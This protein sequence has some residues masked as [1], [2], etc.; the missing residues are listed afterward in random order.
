MGELILQNGASLT[1]SGNLTNSGGLYVNTGGSGGSNLTVEGTLTNSALVQIG[2]NDLATTVTAEG[3][4]NSGTFY[5]YVDSTLTTSGNVTNSDEL[6]VYGGL[7]IGGTLTNSD[8]VAIGNGSQAT[9]VTAQGLSNTA[10]G[11]IDIEGG[12]TNR[13]LLNITG[14]A[15]APTIWTG[16]LDISGDGVLEFNN[17]TIGTIASGAEIYLSGSE[18]WVADAGA[19]T[20]NT[21]LSGLSSIVG[22]LILQNGASLTTSGNLTNS[23][24]L[25]VNTGGSGGSNLT[26][27]GTLTNS[28]LV[29]IGNNDLATT[30]TAEG[31]NNSGTFYIYVDSTLTT[32]GNVTNSDE[33]FVY[34][35]LTIGGTLTNSDV[36]AIGNGSQATTVTAQ[37]LSNTA[38]GT[39]DIEGNGATLNVSGSMTDDGTISGAGTLILTGTFLKSAGGTTTISTAFDNDGTV[40]VESGTLNLT[41]GGTDTGSFYEG[42]GVLEFGGTRTIN[43]VTLSGYSGTLTIDNSGTLNFVTAA[44]AINFSN[45]TNEGGS[46]SEQIDNVRVTF[47]DTTV[48]GGAITETGAGAQINVDAGNTLTLTNTTLTLSN[49]TLGNGAL[50]VAGTLDVA[51][52]VTLAGSGVV[53]IASGG[54]ADFQDTMNLAAAFLGVGMLQLAHSAND[55]S[56]TIS[57]FGLGD[58]LDL[59]DLSYEPGEYTAWSQS[60][61]TLLIYYSG[62]STPAETLNIAGT[63]TTANF[64]LTGDA[65]GGTSGGTEVLYVPSSGPTVDSWTGAGIAGDWYDP[66]NWTNGVPTSNS[67]V[68]INPASAATI[69]IS[70]ATV[71]SI[72][73]NSNVTLDI[74]GGTLAVTSSADILGPVEVAGGATL[75]ARP[76]RWTSSATPASCKSAMTAH[77]I[78]PATSTIAVGRSRPTRTRPARRSS[79]AI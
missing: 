11:T 55:T 40:N 29:Q 78:S 75:N 54:I 12:S 22:E 5:I 59:Q 49:T 1:T 26:V 28:A 79:L 6:F 60:T 70:G 72:D 76:G 47:D 23:G 32:S 62:S 66:N 36:V 17:G 61:G 10:A 18:A 64:S 9:T 52:S 25:Y 53:T 20:G 4:N 38:A 31:L 45:L 37:G 68:E 43:D 50:L 41:G 2:N 73:T 67:E 21:A 51:S 7:T 34:G 48:S 3:L 58:A 15:G 39:I 8:V 42:S 14:A 69:T 57:G 13:A 71:Y 63:Y 24:G 74:E 30:V 33:L 19:L 46:D 77:S 56:G 16:T 35:G 44:S 65:S 27:E